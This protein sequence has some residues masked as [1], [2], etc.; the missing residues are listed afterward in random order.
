VG[1]S[2]RLAQSIAGYPLA[3]PGVT[4]GGW[5]SRAC[6]ESPRGQIQ[7]AAKMDINVDNAAVGPKAAFD[8]ALDQ[9][10]VRDNGGGHKSRFNPDDPAARSYR[11]ACL[12]GLFS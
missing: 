1:R 11:P 6:G 5:A 10:S 9:D 4:G 8:T 12:P 2:L 3:S 7:V